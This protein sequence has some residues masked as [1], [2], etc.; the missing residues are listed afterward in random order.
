[1]RKKAKLRLFFLYGLIGVALLAF[2]ALDP[3]LVVNKYTIRSENL[4]SAFD[5]FTI[6]QITDLHCARFGEKQKDLLARID[7][8][9]P[10]IVVLTGDIID[11]KLLDFAPVEELVTGLAAKYPVYSIWGNHDRWLSRRDFKKL[12]EIY[13]SAGVTILNDESIEFSHNNAAIFLHGADDPPVWNRGDLAYVQ[14]H[15]IA[16]SPTEDRFNLLLMHRA[17]LFPALSDLGFDLVLSGHLHGGQIRIPYVAGLIS[18]TR[19]WFP[20]YSAGR[21]EENG[22]VMIVGRGLGNAI[23]IPRIF[24]PPELV[25]IV[26]KTSEK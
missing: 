13:K 22:T 8:I 12:Q 11:E 16:V 26:L 4:P 18:P 5:G 9:A 20:K 23:S 25:H 2:F 6:V 24:N 3:R 19:E 14:E 1:M 10:D 15:G 21:F 7:R 17:N